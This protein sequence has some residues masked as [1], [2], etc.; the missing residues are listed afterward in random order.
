MA[1]KEK[2]SDMYTL[3]QAFNLFKTKVNFKAFLLKKYKGQKKSYKEWQ[4]C[5]K[6][7]GLL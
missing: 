1:K 5:F 7:E 3:T 6:S 4:D 2:V